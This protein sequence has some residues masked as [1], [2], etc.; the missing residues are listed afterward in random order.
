MSAWTQSKPCAACPYRRDTPT[1]VWSPEEYERLLA[2]D[3][4][5]MGATYGCHLNSARPE[6]EG[7]PCAGWLA[8]QKRRGV[9]SI[10]LRMVLMTTPDAATLYEKID[11]KDPSLYGSI[12]EMV[13]ANMGKRFPRRNTKARRLLSKL[14]KDSP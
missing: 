5:D 6:S 8:D 2:N 4:H 7:E 12:E 1:G 9:P 10:R 11:D 14:G 3:G 13:R